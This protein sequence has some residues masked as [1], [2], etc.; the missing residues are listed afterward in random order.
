MD[1]TARTRATYA[2]RIATPAL[3][4]LIRIRKTERSEGRTSR[5]SHIATTATPTC[6]AVAGDIWPAHPPTTVGA[7]RT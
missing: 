3:P 6:W 2:V 4:D 7:D 1:N 5:S